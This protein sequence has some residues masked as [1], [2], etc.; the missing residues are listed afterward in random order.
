MKCPF[1]K[2]DVNA[3]KFKEEFCECDREQCMAYNK[4]DMSCNLCSHKR[5]FNIEIK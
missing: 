3:G 2:Q 1:K 5:V 4:E